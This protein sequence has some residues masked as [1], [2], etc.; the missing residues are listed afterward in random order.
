MNGIHAII[1]ATG[2]LSHL[3][4]EALVLL[5]EEAAKEAGATV[6][7]S[8]V[9]KFGAGFGNTGVVLLAES[10]ITVHT[11][12]EDN[13]AAFDIFM[14]GDRVNLHRAV[15]VIKARDPAGLYRVEVIERGI[16]RLQAVSFEGIAE[17]ILAETP[18][19][20]KNLKRRIGLSKSDAT[21]G[22]VE[23]LKFLELC[24]VTSIDL[25]PSSLIDILWREFILCTRSYS[26]FCQRHFGGF[27]HYQSSEGGPEASRQYQRTIDQ[28][29]EHFGCPDPKFWGS[30]GVYDAPVDS[31]QA[32]ESTLSHRSV[33]SN[34]NNDIRG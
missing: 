24:S 4:A 32:G 5:M 10:H 8:C 7:G 14:C 16:K 11:W 17:Q 1:E 2:K 31:T 15:D 23:L 34:H 20:E 12:P 13:Y 6:L 30:A 22:L 25:R 28:Y 9:H 26:A 27:L 18:R 3:S 21:A 33:E 29:V 19:L